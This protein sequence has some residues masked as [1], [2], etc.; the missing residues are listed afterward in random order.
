[1]TLIRIASL[2][3]FVCLF[4]FVGEKCAFIHYE[5]THI[6]VQSK[7]IHFVIFRLY[8]YPSVVYLSLSLSTLLTPDE[9]SFLDGLISVVIVAVP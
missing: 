9:F 8:F 4:H 2:T 3:Q 5:S 6:V 1:M 7:D